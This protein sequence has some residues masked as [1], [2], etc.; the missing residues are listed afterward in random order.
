MEYST[1]HHDRCNREE[2]ISVKDP[3]LYIDKESLLN[4][5]IE[6]YIQQGYSKSNA[7]QEAQKI[8]YCGK[9][10]FEIA[11]KYNIEGNCEYWCDCIYNITNA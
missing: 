3:A 1:E 4:K 2:K 5:Y 9:T 7:C 10:V 8:I 11:Q 6:R